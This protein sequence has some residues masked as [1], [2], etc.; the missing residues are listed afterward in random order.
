MP[1]FEIE[2]PYGRDS[3][4]QSVTDERLEEKLRQ[5]LSPEAVEELLKMMKDDP[6]IAGH[7]GDITQNPEKIENAIQK[8]KEAGNQGKD[9]DAIQGVDHEYEAIA[10]GAHKNAV[11]EKEGQSQ[12]GK[13]QSFGVNQDIINQI[14]LGE[15]EGKPKQQTVIIPRDILEALGRMGTVVVVETNGPGEDIT[16]SQDI[17]QRQRADRLAPEKE[18]QIQMG[19]G[20][21]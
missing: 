16:S 21:R 12:D 1:V 15:L 17:E 6:T 18:Q 14:S 8:G 13:L 7:L 11:K 19:G 4:P 2:R 5:S 9:A 20:R 10:K 3:E